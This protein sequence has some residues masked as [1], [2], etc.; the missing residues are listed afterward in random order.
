MVGIDSRSGWVVIVCRIERLLLL[1][2]HRG[3][4]VLR[5]DQDH[6]GRYKGA[7]DAQQNNVGTRPLVGS[8]GIEF[9]ALFV[10]IQPV[11]VNLL[12]HVPIIDATVTIF[13][14]RSILIR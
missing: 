5:H 2:N 4:L 12:T 3:S 9:L 6:H 7:H 14:K 13:V 8:K 11:S 10:A 1:D